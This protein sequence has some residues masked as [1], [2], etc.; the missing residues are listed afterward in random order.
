MN[1]QVKISE[2]AKAD[3]NSTYEFYEKQA[4]N[5]GKYFFDN[6]ISEIE[7]LTFYG[8]LHQ[9]FY[10]YHRMVSKKF[11]Y[12]IYY[13]CNK[14]KKEIIAVAIL[15]LRQNPTKINLYLKDRK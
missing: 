12:A 3:L 6:I 11:P 8:C 5:L 14:E 7:M 4:V 1:F 13:N 15:D 2:Y 10:G 9:K